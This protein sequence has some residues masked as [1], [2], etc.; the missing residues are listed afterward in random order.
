MKSCSKAGDALKAYARKAATIAGKFEGYRAARHLYERFPGW[1]KAEMPSR[2]GDRSRAGSR[3]RG[4]ALDSLPLSHG[5]A[6]VHHL[7]NEVA[8]MQAGQIVE[9]GPPSQVL[10]RP[11]HPYTKLLLLAIPRVGLLPQE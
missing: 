11:A 5:F 10:H 4:C 6:L 9:R 3:R 2:A 8:V 7:C 1:E